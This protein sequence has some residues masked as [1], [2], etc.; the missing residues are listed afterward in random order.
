MGYQ[1]L[2]I[3]H[4]WGAPAVGVASGGRS[5]GVGRSFLR[6]GMWRSF[7][8][9]ATGQIPS[10]R[11]QP[12]SNANLRAMPMGPGERSS[13]HRLFY[14]F[15]PRFVTSSN[16]ISHIFSTSIKWNGPLDPPKS[17]QGVIKDLEENP[18][19]VGCQKRQFWLD[20][21]RE[22]I[23]SHFLVWQDFLLEEHKRDFIY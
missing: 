20:I 5:G 9:V 6:I 18:V 10:L 4:Q 2:L 23:Q 11:L 13:C 22:K 14:R 19:T 16:C 15:F 3:M 17:F 1:Q 7:G 8:P 12:K 21:S